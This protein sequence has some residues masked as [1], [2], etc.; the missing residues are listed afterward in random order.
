MAPTKRSTAPVNDS[1][2][3]ADRSLGGVLYFAGFDT[4]QQ[5]P[6]DILWKSDGTAAR[7][8]PAVDRD[9]NFIYW[10][11]SFEVLG[12]KLFFTD[13]SDQLWQSDGTPAGT[14]PLGLRPRFRH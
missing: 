6:S 14:F 3:P 1:M 12:G 4:T 9:G 11:R 13:Q 5:R 10:P 7:T 8:A 2:T